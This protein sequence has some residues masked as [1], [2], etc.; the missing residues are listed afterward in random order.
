MVGFNLPSWG[1]YSWITL[2][3]LL[4]K[5]LKYEYFFP[6]LWWNGWCVIYL[7]ATVLSFM[8]KGHWGMGA[9]WIPCGNTQKS[10]DSVHTTESL[11]ACRHEWARVDAWY[12]VEEN[13]SFPPSARFGEIS[14]K[15]SLQNLKDVIQEYRSGGKNYS[16]RTVFFRSIL[17]TSSKNSTWSSLGKRRLY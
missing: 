4:L 2:L 7:L 15:G 9:D 10:V 12:T 5:L 11:L 14:G 1:F 16:Y 8:S 3:N 6:A 17:V 13:L